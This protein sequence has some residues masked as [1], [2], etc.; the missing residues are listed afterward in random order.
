MKAYLLTAL[1][2]LGIATG[3][4]AQQQEPQPQ[5]APAVYIKPQ[6]LFLVNDQETTMRAMILSPDDIIS[7]DVVKAAA[8]IERFG[9]KGKD[10]VVILTLKQALPLAR[11][12]DVYKAYNVPEMYQ[13]L[14][15]AINGVHI[16]DT[17]LLLA[18]LRQIEKVEATDFENTMSRWSYDKQFLNI[19]TKQQ[20]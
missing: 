2:A 8:A 1:V 3:A 11:V 13:K 14:S 7:M 18:D 10:G 4:Q 19:V 17:A 5:N 20:N 9:E 6:P 12:T 15:L 16:T